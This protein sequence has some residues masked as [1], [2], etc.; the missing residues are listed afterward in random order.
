MNSKISTGDSFATGIKCFVI[1]LRIQTLA[2]LW[3]EIVLDRGLSLFV[4]DTNLVNFHIT[5]IVAHYFYNWFVCSS[6]LFTCG[7]CMLVY[8]ISFCAFLVHYIKKHKSMKKWYYNECQQ[9]TIT[10]FEN[11]MVAGL[12]CFSVR[13]TE[14]VVLVLTKA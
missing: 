14:S 6:F 10:K 4:P 5:K 13:Q 2:S 7:L 11:S 1:F 9:I 12:A 8:E 3:T